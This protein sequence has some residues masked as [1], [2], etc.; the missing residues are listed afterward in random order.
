MN[1]AQTALNEKDRFLAEVDRVLHSETLRTSEVSRRLLKFLAEKSASGEAEQLKEYTIAV[2]A[3]DKP[4]SN[5]PRHDSTVRIQMGRLRRKLAEY[6]SSEAKDSEFA[7]DL[8]RGRFRLVC[9]PHGA[10][11]TS[12]VRN[13]VSVPSGVLWTAGAMWLSLLAAVVWVVVSP[14]FS[15]VESVSAAS[16]NTWNKSLD[17]LW[18]GYLAGKRPLVIA[19][20]DPLFW[21]ARIPGERLVVRDPNL[22][23]DEF[24][25]APYMRQLRKALDNPGSFPTHYYGTYGE[26]GAAFVLGK[27]LGTR[28][29]NISVVRVSELSQQQLADS[30][31]V[32][33]GKEAH[34][35]EQLQS[36]P[37][38]PQL[39]LI[40]HGVHDAAPK[41]GDPADYINPHRGEETGEVY[42]LVSQLPGP[43][44]SGDVRIFTSG[45]A[46]GYMGA[47]Q[48]FTDPSSA[49]T[50]MASLRK[51]QG[52]LP[53]YYQV[54]LLIRYADQ[55]PVETH[56]VLTRELHPSGVGGN[57]LSLRKP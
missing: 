7:I 12:V 41:A 8:P 18:G 9:V 10:P 11:N 21:A 37:I 19:M 49:E 46:I 48:A 38:Q 1:A 45:H 54:V 33:I 55:V 56:L 35:Q 15:T 16:K 14:R 28:T 27:T 22:S 20:E 47:V 26:I 43:L 30:N 2:D 6:Y 23:W 32:V 3:L 40:E 36:S 13:R 29:E 25:A 24:Q 52:D 31:V 39:S 57:E 44:G 17:D 42:A 5:D 53:R 50:I 51:P 34:F 4:S